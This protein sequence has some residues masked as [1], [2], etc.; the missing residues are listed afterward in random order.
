MTNIESN[1]ICRQECEDGDQ[2]EPETFV[3]SFLSSLLIYE[4]CQSDTEITAANN[5]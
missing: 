4:Q 5:S 3:L 1:C 2:L